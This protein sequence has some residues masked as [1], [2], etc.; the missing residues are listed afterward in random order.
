MSDSKKPEALTV[1]DFMARYVDPEVIRSVIDPA[2][3]ARAYG[4]DLKP[5]TRAERARFAIR[6]KRDEWRERLALWIAPWLEGGE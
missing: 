4:M 3:T 5:R 1:G 6:N 2:F